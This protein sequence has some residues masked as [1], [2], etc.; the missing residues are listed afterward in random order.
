[1][2]QELINI[3]KNTDSNLITLYNVDESL[4]NE[5]QLHHENLNIIRSRNIIYIKYVRGDI[6]YDGY[7]SYSL[8]EEVKNGYYDKHYP[9]CG[10]RNTF[11]YQK[12][13]VVARKRKLNKLR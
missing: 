12:I 11:D 1:M 7:D 5:L 8:L 4:I 13:K 3:I 2:K 10:Y 6:Q 9:N